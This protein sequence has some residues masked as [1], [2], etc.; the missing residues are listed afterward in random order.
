MEIGIPRKLWINLARRQM[1]RRKA[2]FGNQANVCKGCTEILLCSGPISFQVCETLDDMIATGLMSG[3]KKTPWQRLRR[4]YL[5]VSEECLKKYGI[6][7]KNGKLVRG[8]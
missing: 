4:K 6:L 1:A 8:K 3:P 7:V 2:I 5:P